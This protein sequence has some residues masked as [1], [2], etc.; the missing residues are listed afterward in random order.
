RGSVL[1]FMAAGGLRG[2]SPMSPV[3]QMVPPNT[4]RVVGDRGDVPEAYIPL[5]GSRRSLALLDE[6]AARLGRIA[7][8][9]VGFANGAVTRAPSP[10]SAG[11]FPSGAGDTYIVDGL[12]LAESEVPAEVAAFFRDV[13]RHARQRAGVR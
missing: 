8:P 9:A 4:W 6:A 7:V 12:T 13:R 2:L 10:V 1:E 3:A 5:D 11:G